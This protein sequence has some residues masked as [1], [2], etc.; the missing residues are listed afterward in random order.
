MRQARVLPRLM[1]K[2]EPHGQAADYRAGI[3]RAGRP[4]RAED[5]RDW[6]GSARCTEADPE[7]FFPPRNNPGRAARAV[8]AGCEVRAQCLAYATVHAQENYGIWGGL[9]RVERIRLRDALRGRRAGRPPD[10]A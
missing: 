1:P 8:C 10:A 4:G 3:C 6:T 2:G 7:I 5:R 9:S